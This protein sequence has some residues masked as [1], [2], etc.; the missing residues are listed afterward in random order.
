[1]GAA[2]G[3]SRRASACS[4]SRLPR[5]P[6]TRRTSPRCRPT[7]QASRPSP[8]PPC[9]TST[10]STRAS[11]TAQARLAALQAAARGSKPSGAALRQALQVARPRHARLAEPPREPAALHLRPR[12]DEHARHLLGAKS[13]ED[14]LTQLD[15]FNRVAP[16]TPTCCSRYGARE[17]PH[18][19]APARRS[20]HVR[21][22]SRPRRRAAATTVS[23]LAQ[24]EG[25]ARRVHRRAR[26]AALPRRR[27]DR[28]DLGAGRRGRRRSR[29]SSRRRLARRTPDVSAPVT[30]VVLTTPSRAG[31][32]LTVVATGYALPGPHRDAA[33]RSAGASPPSTRP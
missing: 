21:E 25:R 29:S 14:A 32:T 2:A 5:A 28:A 10:R 7:T 15:D 33:S 31:R 1:M 27:A 20:P 30:A 19:R 16:P 23:E 3:R 18:R 13:L 26:P 17:A 11:P 24:R 6:G 8:A 12:D 4:R 22:R 9:S